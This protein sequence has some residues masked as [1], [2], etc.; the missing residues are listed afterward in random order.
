MSEPKKSLRFCKSGHK[1]YKSSDCPTCPVCE[2]EGKPEDGFL[3]KLNAPAR[4]ALVNKKILTLIKLSTFTETEILQFH[5]IG[6]SSIPLF[7]NELKSNKLS[8]R[9]SK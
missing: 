5:G 8:F 2:K 1:Y 9:K 7:K 4:R 6:P 3:S